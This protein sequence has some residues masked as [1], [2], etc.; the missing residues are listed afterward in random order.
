MPL[1]WSLLQR[2]IFTPGNQKELGNGLALPHWRTPSR[3]SLYDRI[4]DPFSGP[5]PWAS[6]M[7]PA[8]RL[9]ERGR[10]VVLWRTGLL[11]AV[12]CG[13]EDH[14]RRLSRGQ[15]EGDD[16]VSGGDPVA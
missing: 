4:A 9:Q 5:G 12:R 6:G 8:W 7:D 14:L 3:V 1:I 11:R 15:H 10:R 16:P 2:T 13:R